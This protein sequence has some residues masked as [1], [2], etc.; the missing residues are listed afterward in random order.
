MKA[1]FANLYKDDAIS[2]NRRD[3]TQKASKNV[4]Q[5]EGNAFQ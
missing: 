1:L 5:P 3:A 2:Y 4:S